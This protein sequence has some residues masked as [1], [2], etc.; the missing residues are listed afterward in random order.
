MLL[1]LQLSSSISALVSQ[2]VHKEWII[3]T[4]ASNHMTSQLGLLDRIKVVPKSEMRQVNLP[5]GDV[6]SMSHVGT[7]KVNSHYTIQNGLFIPYFK[8]N[9]LSVSQLTKAYQ[10]P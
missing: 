8:C 5:T 7:T 1:K 9:L 2:Y 3:D 4:G 6:V 10:R